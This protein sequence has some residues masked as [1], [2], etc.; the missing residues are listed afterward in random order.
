VSIVTR[1][2]ATTMNEYLNAIPIL[3]FMTGKPIRTMAVMWRME[4][5]IF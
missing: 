5:G 3:H 1:P 4:K 2:D